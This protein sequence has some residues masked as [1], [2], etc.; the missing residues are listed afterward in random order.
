MEGQ[1]SLASLAFRGAGL[2]NW[3]DET[4][5]ERSSES[6]STGPECAFHPRKASAGDCS[7]YTWGMFYLAATGRGQRVFRN[8]WAQS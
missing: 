1:S 8:S 5:K 3:D 6:L 2:Q 4:F 7:R